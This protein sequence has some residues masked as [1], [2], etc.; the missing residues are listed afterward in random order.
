MSRV[1]LLK[2]EDVRKSAR[3]TVILIFAVLTLS[4]FSAARSYSAEQPIAP[5]PEQ[6]KKELR[7]QEGREPEKKETPEKRNE[8]I[9][10]KL[11]PI[12]MVFVKGGCFQMGDVTGEG[13][14]DERPA[15]EVCLSDYYI[16]ETVVT[17]GLYYTVMDISDP[18]TDPDKPV[19][20]V[21]YVDALRF[22]KTLKEVTKGFYRLP[23][24]AEW[25]YAARSRGQKEIWP[26]VNN[27]AELGDYAWFADNSNNEVHKVRQKKPNGLKLY[28]MA[29]N[30][31]EWTEDNFD[32]DFYKRSSKR[33]PFNATSS[34]WRTV[35][36]GSI[37]DNAY[38]I[39][40]TYRYAIE[41]GRKLGN[42]GF[43]LAE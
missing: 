4:I 29:G 33:D 15:H 2:E 35:R 6:L 42:L 24:E 38:K 3:T 21:N 22:I 18:P 27:E 14:E 19:T 39:R 5:T 32:F 40:T 10:K 36:G 41:P 26:G 9:R 13:D 20:F 12:R 11:P 17:Q 23:T 30:V 31:W 8:R 1:H 7:E 43:R 28:D 37:V 34:Q 16:G 25:E